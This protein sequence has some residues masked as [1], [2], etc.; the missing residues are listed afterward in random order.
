MNGSSGPLEAV[1]S[2][3]NGGESGGVSAAEALVRGPDPPGRPRYVIRSSKGIRKPACAACLQIIEPWKDST[4]DRSLPASLLLILYRH[5]ATHTPTQ[6]AYNMGHGKGG[7]SATCLDVMTVVPTPKQSDTWGY[8][9]IGV[10]P[11]RQKQPPSCFRHR[12]C[13]QRATLMGQWIFCKLLSSVG[14]CFLHA[15]AWIS[16]ARQGIQPSFLAAHSLWPCGRVD[17]HAGLVRNGLGETI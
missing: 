2:S 6:H 14:F 12:K 11:V 17:T 15:Q 10:C 8:L 3:H 1:K 4:T 9:Q 16:A 13:K 7:C 5:V